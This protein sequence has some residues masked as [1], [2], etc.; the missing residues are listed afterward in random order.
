MHNVVRLPHHSQGGREGGREGG[1]ALESGYEGGHSINDI[2][3]FKLVPHKYDSLHLFHSMASIALTLN[4]LAI[5]NLKPA[6]QLNQHQ[7]N[8]QC[9]VVQQCT[10]LFDCPVLPCLA[11]KRKPPGVAASHQ[12]LPKVIGQP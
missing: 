6:Q 12:V 7:R 8:V 4:G 3:Y 11:M 9:N 10:M 5:R 2:H 1:R